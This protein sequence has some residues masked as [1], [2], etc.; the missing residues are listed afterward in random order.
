MQSLREIAGRLRRPR[1]DQFVCVTVT[2][3][4]PAAVTAVAR[5]LAS[6]TTTVEMAHRVAESDPDPIRLDITCVPVTPVRPIGR[7]AR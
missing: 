6:V 1:P 3:A 7:A 4:N 2:G 5:A